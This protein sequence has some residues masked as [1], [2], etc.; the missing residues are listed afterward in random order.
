MIIS[1]VMRVNGVM[2]VRMTVTHT[3]RAAVAASWSVTCFVYLAL[4]MEGLF[5]VFIRGSKQSGLVVVIVPFSFSLNLRWRIV[6]V[7]I[8]FRAVGGRDCCRCICPSSPLRSTVC[9]R[10]LGAHAVSLRGSTVAD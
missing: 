3:L 2:M 4:V 6:L 7:V 9:G 8:L 1:D 5:D 10:V